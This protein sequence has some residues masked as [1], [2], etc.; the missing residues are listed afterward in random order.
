MNT[1]N[2]IENLIKGYYKWL[3]DNTVVKYDGST[4]W[5]AINTP[6]VGLMND[7]IEIFVKNTEGKILLSDDGE[8]IWNLEMSGVNIS[9]SPSRKK[10]IQNIENNFG[11]KIINDEIIAE[12]NRDNFYKRKHSILQAIQQISDL[13]MTA[14]HDIV[15]MFSEDLKQYLDNNDVLY[16]PQIILLGKSGLNFNFDFQTIGKKQETVIKTYNQLGK[17]NVTDLLFGINDVRDA[18]Q[19]ST[20]KELHCV[21]VV[22]DMDKEPKKEYLNALREYNCKPLLWSEREKTWDSQNLISA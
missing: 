7:N 1:T 17:Q 2:N 15:S 6:F 3:C 19:E 4:D 10:I 22:N 21:V 9:K 5:H 8:T 13:K 14:K 12:A 11:V 16:T 20:G 18:R